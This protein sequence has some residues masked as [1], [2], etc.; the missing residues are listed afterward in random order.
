MAHCLVLLTLDHKVLGLNPAGGRFQL[1]HQG[2][3]LYS[4]YPLKPHFYTVKLGFTGVFINF[5]ISAQKH[6]VL[7]SAHNL[8]FGQ[9]Y[10]KI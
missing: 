8:C 6:A 4:F 1:M 5:L 10:E 3:A 9:K 7:T 2:N